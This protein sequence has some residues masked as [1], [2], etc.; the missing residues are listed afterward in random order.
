MC[1]WTKEQE[2]SLDGEEVAERAKWAQ[3][4]DAA[5]KNLE[6]KNHCASICFQCKV[7]NPTAHGPD[8]CPSPSQ[9]C[10]ELSR[11]GPVYYALS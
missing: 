7:F 3:T 5:L 10:L 9:S 8:S 1:D 2:G 11:P 6:K 4:V